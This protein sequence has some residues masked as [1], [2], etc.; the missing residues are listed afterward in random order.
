MPLV[1]MTNAESMIYNLHA[2]SNAPVY[3][4][5]LWS[6]C[7]HCPPFRQTVEETLKDLPNVRVNVVMY[8]D[9]PE[10]VAQ[11]TTGFPTLRKKAGKTITEFA[12][13]PTKE[14]LMEFFHGEGGG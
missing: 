9:D 10:A 6:K 4:L 3:T 8:D 14:N 5:Y 13:R 2:R 7:P 1:P 12:R 11:Q